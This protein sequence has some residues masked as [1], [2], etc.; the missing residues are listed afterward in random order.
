MPQVPRQVPA[1]VWNHLD[2]QQTVAEDPA[3]ESWRV[4]KSRGEQNQPTKLSLQDKVPAVRKTSSAA[5]WATC[6][7]EAFAT[8]PVSRTNLGSRILATWPVHVRRLDE[9]CR[10]TQVLTGFDTWRGARRR[11]NCQAWW[12]EPHS[13]GETRN[14]ADRPSAAPV[15]IPV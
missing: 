6:A 4:H 5:T 8:P 11:K 15:L 2:I 14:H 10:N 13:N 7:R 12:R 3:N 1:A 9:Y